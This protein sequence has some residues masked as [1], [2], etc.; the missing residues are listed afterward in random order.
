MMPAGRC[1]QTVMKIHVFTDPL[2]SFPSPFITPCTAG[3]ST[4]LRCWAA[5]PAR[6]TQR[7]RPV[8]NRVCRIGDIC[9]AA[10]ARGALPFTLWQLSWSIPQ[11]MAGT[12]GFEPPNPGVKF[13]CLTAWPC[14]L[15]AGAFFLCPAK[16]R[17][18][19]P[20]TLSHLHGFIL[21][22]VKSTLSGLGGSVRIRTEVSWIMSPAL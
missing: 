1:A 12:D 11:G 20:M 7:P 3:P 6:H 16:G 14:P 17:L 13:P 5:D 19:H 22:Y 4:P 18:F 9:G 21:R 2:P 8:A 15:V 10:P